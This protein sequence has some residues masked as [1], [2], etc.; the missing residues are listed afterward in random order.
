MNQQATETD[1]APTG[2]EAPGAPF[3]R[4][5]SIWISDAH[6]GWRPCEAA[7]L[8]DFLKHHDAQYW[9]LVGDMVDGWMLKR[10]WYWPQ[11]HNDVVQKLLRKARKGARVV[12]VPG[13]H[14]EFARRFVPIQ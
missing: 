10:N 7:R 3:R 13:N 8:L 1:A 14:D 4:Y 2:A 5:R 11:E 12:Y 6:L 9:Y